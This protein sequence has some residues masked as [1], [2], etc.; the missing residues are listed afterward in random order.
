[1]TIASSKYTD[2]DDGLHPYK[3][4]DYYEWWY[5]D[6][7]FDN[8]YSCV[9]VY[10]WK[11]GF[12]QPRIPV[13][14]K[15]IYTP[16][17]EKISTGK[18]MRPEDC[19]AK[20]DGCDVNMMGSFIRQ[21]GNNYRIYAPGTTTSVDLTFKRVVPPWK[22]LGTGRLY[23][24]HDQVQGWLAP[25]PRADVE[26][27]IS[28]RG[29]E[30]KVKGKGYH[31]HNWGNVSMHESLSYWWWGRFHHPE[32]TLIYYYLYPARTNEPDIPRLFLAKGDKVLMTPEKVELKA[33]NPKIDGVTGQMIPRTLNITATEGDNSVQLE[34][35]TSSIFD[36]NTL[37]M[38]APWPV[39]YWRFKADYR[40]KIK[41]GKQVD[42]ISGK[43][44]SEYELL[45]PSESPYK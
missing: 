30:M 23:D 26:G 29:K 45:R 19:T 12:L 22:P 21:E 25:C 32:Y 39:Y 27:T 40:C 28:V 33:S 3:T 20:E 1:M 9:V 18:V 4:P 11:C 37:P 16:E 43:T 24:N 34:V 42:E 15:E 17:G 14:T 35:V 7:H 41:I 2:K 6:A 13:V 36:T 38:M 31:D 5:S 8:G 44:M 10:H